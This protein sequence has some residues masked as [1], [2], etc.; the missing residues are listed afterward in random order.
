MSRVGILLKQFLLVLGDYAVFHMA[1]ILTLLLRFGA[2][3]SSDWK[4]HI[5]PFAILGLLWVVSFYINGL[6]DLLLT[7]DHLKFFRAYIEGM[8]VNLLMGLA[9]F[10]IIPFGIAPRTNLLLHFAFALLLGYAW[11]MLYNRLLVPRLFHNR[12]L[13]IG[14]PAEATRLREL[15][16]HS[17]FGFELAATIETAPIAQETGTPIQWRASFDTLEQLLIEKNIQTI[18]LGHRPDEVP[19]LREALYKTLF[20]N[21]AI[22][23]RAHLEETLTGRI[24]LEHVSQIWFL[25]NLRENEKAWYENVKRLMDITLAIPFGVLT[26]ALFP[27]V[28]LFTKLT[29]P[30][31]V[32]F[33]QVRIGRFGHP[34]RIW[35]F[36]TMV[37]T[38]PDGSAELEGKAQFAQTNDPRITSFGKFMR[39]VRLDELPQI[40]NVLRG[41][42]SFIGPR[43]ERPEFVATLTEQMPFY[44]LR[45]LTRPG[46]TG[47]AQVRFPYAGTFEDNLKKLQYDLFYIRHRSPML[48][49]SILLRTIGIVLRRKGT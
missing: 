7:R 13:F 29:S 38:A 8:I 47:W 4:I 32:L 14:Q 31:P 33:S 21:V 17:P 30:G 44:A 27:L 45:H 36:R 22:L 48:D 1:L 10:Y 42:M 40:W 9:Y 15:F 28:A 46:L 39:T 3:R 20:T 41:E 2:L 23:D 16:E 18:V 5:L 35:K 26:A 11:R 34:F 6:Y 25:E 12:V 37:A 43:P 19:G 24:P 49:L